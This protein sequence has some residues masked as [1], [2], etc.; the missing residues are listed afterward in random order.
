MGNMVNLITRMVSMEIVW[1]QCGEGY[2]LMVGGGGGGGIHGKNKA[3][4]IP[5]NLYINYSIKSPQKV[6][7]SILLPTV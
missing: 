3:N 4:Q 2:F 1:R 7:L 6:A 5:G